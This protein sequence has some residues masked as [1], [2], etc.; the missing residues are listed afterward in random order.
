MIWIGLGTNQGNR[1]ANMLQALSM[2]EKEQF[3]LKTLSSLYETAPWGITDQ[4]SF[5]NAV[6]TVEKTFSPIEMLERM[7]K[8]EKKMGHKPERRQNNPQQK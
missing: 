4:P 1:V 2:M 8:I 3:R 7:L 6:V 5:L